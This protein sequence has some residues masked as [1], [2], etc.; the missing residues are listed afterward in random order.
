MCSCNNPQPP[1]NAWIN[2]PLGLILTHSTST[3][4]SPIICNARLNHTAPYQPICPNPLWSKQQLNPSLVPQTNFPKCIVQSTCHPSYH[5]IVIGNPTITT[6]YT[7]R[8]SHI[9]EWVFRSAWGLLP[10]ENQ[11]IP[12]APKIGL[13]MEFS[14]QVLVV[15]PLVLY[16]SH[17]PLYHLSSHIS[18]FQTLTSVYC[19]TLHIHTLNGSPK[20]PNSDEP[21][22]LSLV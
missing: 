21:S 5:A 13:L 11:P 3:P 19:P 22:G 20:S 8:S 14:L 2:S 4:F 18:F 16:L 12:L 7:V 1:I 6:Q 9:L 10:S 15:W 17:N